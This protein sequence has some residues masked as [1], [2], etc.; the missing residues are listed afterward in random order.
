MIHARMF[1]DKEGYRR[2]FWRECGMP[3][4]DRPL[5]AQFCGH[6]KDVLLSAMKIVENHVDGVDGES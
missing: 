6:D 1:M 5:I 4:E 3:A 2:K